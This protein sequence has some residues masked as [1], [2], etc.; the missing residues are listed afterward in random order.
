MHKNIFFVLFKQIRVQAAQLLG[1]MENVG[2]EFLHQTLDKK[3][4]SNMRVRKLNKF[5]TTSK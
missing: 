3:L 1:R 5:L 2:N 4:M